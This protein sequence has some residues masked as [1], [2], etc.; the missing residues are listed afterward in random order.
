MG[1]IPLTRDQQ[2]AVLAEYDVNPAL[3]EEN[4]VELHRMNS[5]PDVLIIRYRVVAKVD[6]ARMQR[7]FFG[8]IEATPA[9]GST[10]AP[11]PADEDA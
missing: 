3:V 9:S 8:D 10:R 11:L 2:L 4:S 7:V 6:R 1:M 5:D